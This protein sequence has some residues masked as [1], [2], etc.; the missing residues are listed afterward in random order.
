MLELATFCALKDNYAYLLHDPASKA[1]ACIDV[2]D[3]APILAELDK[4][5]WALTDIWL[6]HHHWDHIDG[7]APLLDACAARGWTPAVMAAAADMHRLPAHLVTKALSPREQFQFANQ[8]VEVMDVPGHTIGH[9]AYFVVQDKILFSADSL[10]ALGCGRLFEG[11]PQQ[12]WDSLLTL[13]ALP[14]DTLVCS[15]HEYSASNAAFAITVDPEN[16]ALLK[17][18]KDITEKRARDLPTVPTRLKLEKDTNPFL[19]ADTSG[20]KSAVNMINAT[21]LDVFTE[22]RA[23]KDRF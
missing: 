21:D 22:I 13:R 17:R 8:T 18:V 20:V 7:L 4:H 16:S 19:R 1:T 23:R 3:H 12:M 5:G 2:A 9:I 15:G 14:D 11:S 10:M 6:T